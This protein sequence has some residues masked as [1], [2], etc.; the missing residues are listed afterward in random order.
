MKKR[1][2]RIALGLLSGLVAAAIV[3]WLW[4]TAT[5]QVRAFPTPPL[6]QWTP[7]GV[8][9]AGPPPSAVLPAPDAFHTMHVNTVNSDELWTAIAP[10][11]EAD[12]VAETGFYIAEGPTFDN[13]GNLYFSPS[14]SPEDVSLVALDRVTGQRRWSIPGKGAGSGA[15]LV[16]NDPSHPGQQL[17]YHSTYTTAMAL[18]PDG[19]KVW[20]VPTGL[21]LPAHVPGQRSQT[22]MWG[23]NYMPGADAVVAVSMDGWVTAFD[24]KTGTP[25]L[26]S[27]FHLPG[28]PAASLQVRIPKF[29][30]RWANRETAAAFGSTDDGLGLFDTILDVIY[31][32]GVN[33]ANYYAVDPSDDSIVVAATAPDAQDG[34]T[35]GV[36]DNGALYRLRLK[37]SAQGRPSLFISDQFYFSGGTGSTP[38]LSANGRYV[39]VSDD[40]GNVITLDRNFK[41]L[42]RVNVGD[43]VAASVAVAADGNEMYAVTKSDI[44]KLHNVGTSGRIVW[45]ATLDAYPG[46][47]NFNALTPTIVANGVVISIGAGRQLGPSQ[48]GTQFGMGLLD[49]ETGHLRWF[50]PG[51]E[52]SIAVTS[53]GPDGAIYVAHSPVRRAVARGVLG[54]KLPPLMGGIQ[55]YKP[56]RYDLF[57]RDAAC[58][59][60]PLAKRWHAT[61]AEHVNARRDDQA[62]IALLLRQARQAS[63]EA[64]KRHEMTP[65]QL[66]TQS[67]LWERALAATQQAQSA[68][69]VQTIATVCQALQ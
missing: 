60:A 53:I 62:Q 65:A 11:F 44:F 21:T 49:R 30:T 59:A 41:E 68:T 34:K 54:N 57:A 36:S 38:T 15:P 2:L 63:E 61:G 20:S 19:S 10:T 12:W 28:A 27:P 69:A 22:H 25:L 32:N 58:A 37:P 16:L 8:R 42:W 6:S 51:R 26:S 5:P 47:R 31:G 29:L 64:V 4:L 52:E 56:T 18:R 14:W 23:M 17:I 50:A 24:R 33:V 39:V 55:R 43:Q 1:I 3:F 66:A 13:A 9:E 35:D 46:F 67:P 40:N 45:R 48:I 7:P